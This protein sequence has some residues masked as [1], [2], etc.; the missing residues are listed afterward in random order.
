L[1]VTADSIPL[2]MNTPKVDYLANHIN[3]NWIFL[4]WEGITLWEHTGGDDI[5]YY[6]LQWD[7]GTNGQDWV[8]LTSPINGLQY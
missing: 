3:P 7:Q 6:E 2:Y 8:I 1:D 5:I 4:T